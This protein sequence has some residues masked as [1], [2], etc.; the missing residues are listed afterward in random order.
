MLHLSGEAANVGE[1][2]EGMDAWCC[3]GGLLSRAAL[4]LC[5]G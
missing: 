2:R 1:A 3:A 5:I 4:H